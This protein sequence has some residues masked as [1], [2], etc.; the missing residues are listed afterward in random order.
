MKTAF[1]RQFFLSILICVATLT[2]YSQGV[3][4][5]NVD[6]QIEFSDYKYHNASIIATDSGYVVIGERSNG[7]LSTKEGFLM[8]FN[9][10][11][12]VIRTASFGFRNNQYYGY[13]SVR[14]SARTP[15]GGY[16]ISTIDRI[17]PDETN[18]ESDA[19]ILKFSSN[20]QLEWSYYLG[21][22][23]ADEFIYSLA[24]NSSG[25]IAGV[26]TSGT[27][28]ANHTMMAFQLSQNGLLVWSKIFTE[29]G[30]SSAT[31]IKA[32]SN[33][34]LTSF[35]P[36]S[37]SSNVSK[38]VALDNLGNVT[39]QASPLCGCSNVR[40]FSTAPSATNQGYLAVGK[41]VGA[42]VTMK[43]DHTGNPIVQKQFVI[44]GGGSSLAR[45][46]P[47]QD[48]GYIGYGN[49]STV[50]EGMIYV[51]RV[52]EQ[53][54]T[55]WTK[56]IGDTVGG[57]TYTPGGIAQLQN[58]SYVVAAIK[59]NFTASP[60]T[61]YLQ[62]IR[63]EAEAPVQI[64]TITS[65]VVGNGSIS[66]SGT[67]SVPFGQDKTF[68]FTPS[69][70]YQVDSVH[71]D[72]VLIG[73]V[74]A[75]TFQNIDSNHSIRVT[76]GL[77]TGINSVKRTEI[78]AYPNPTTDIITFKVD[79]SVPYICTFFDLTGRK[80]KSVTLVTGNVQVSLNDLPS[81]SYLYQLHTDMHT[82]EILSGRIVLIR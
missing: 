10:E 11:N 4:A 43:I 52:N 77:K 3:Q 8:E 13:N 58:K 78:I 57:F 47:T 29:F 59:Y 50:A 54:D 60:T 18:P 74:T 6:T 1:L 22:T 19:G 55:V 71:V 28:L 40:I 63:I 30:P 64:A 2:G 49:V 36:S 46:I 48:S 9:D 76:F 79:D 44:P 66:P 21:G 68:T 42:F 70:G 41:Q 5:P 80:V 62:I 31:N 23:N 51:V 73:K 27:S 75:H 20:F 15:D 7:N 26:G 37:S 39:W 16:V 33:G 35:S 14:G 69:P 72:G 32:T 12:Q 67:I 65:S 25:S 17:N 38:A 82:K 53:A 61:S 24:V 45:I 81:G 34:W 56:F